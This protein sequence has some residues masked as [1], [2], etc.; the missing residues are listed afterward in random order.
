MTLSKVKSIEPRLF[1]CTVDPD[2]TETIEFGMPRTTVPRWLVPDGGSAEQRLAAQIQEQ[3]VFQIRHFMGDDDVTAFCHHHDLPYDV[4]RKALNGERPMSFENVGQVLHRLSGERIVL[5]HL[6]DP[7]GWMKWTDAERNVRNY[8]TLSTAGF[9]AAVPLIFEGLAPLLWE[10]RLQKTYEGKRKVEQIRE[11]N[12]VLRPAAG[13]VD[14]TGTYLRLF[15][16]ANWQDQVN[17]L[18]SHLTE[19]GRLVIQIYDT[20]ADGTPARV[21]VLELMRENAAGD[22]RFI[23]TIEKVP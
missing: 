21:H 20:H 16:P 22:H 8:G 10:R 19:D 4:F 11:A 3:I 5:E 14:D 1:L 17:A 2:H 7:A 12:S 15:L 6:D 23:A 9:K 18:G 13:Y